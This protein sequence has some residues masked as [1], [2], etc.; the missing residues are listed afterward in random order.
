VSAVLA[1]LVIS[2]FHAVGL[3]YYRD[4]RV[5]QGLGMESPLP[6]ELAY[7]TLFLVFGLV[8]VALLTFALAHTTLPAAARAAVRRGARRPGLAAAVTAMA[9]GLGCLLLAREV[10]DDGV[11]S[12]DEHVYQFIAQT[13][14]T[15]ALTA[16]SP[17]T[18]LEF[19]FEQFVVV[20]DKV[21]Y[22]KYPIGF[23]LLLAAGQALGIERAVV[24]AL[25]GLC[26]LLLVW[27]GRKEFSPGAVMVALL[28]FGLSPQVWITGA[29]L[30]SQ[31]A[32]AACLLGAVGCLLEV[33]RGGPRAAVGTASAGALLAYGILVRPMPGILFAVVAIAWLAAA[34][35]LGVGHVLTTREWPLLL[36]PLAIGPAVLL[37]TNY[38][39]TGH[40]LHSGYQAIHGDAVVLH[41][42]LA[43]TALSVASSVLR[44]NFWLFGWPLS[45]IFCLLARRTPVTLLFWGLIAAEIGYR[46]IAP[47]AGIG[48]VGPVYFYEVVP[49]LCLLTAD[50]IVQLTAR[51]T[52]QSEA[53]TGRALRSDLVAAAIL[54]ATIVNLSLF[55]PY[56]LGDAA[57]SGHSG[58][59]VFRAL[60]RQDV[61]HA[62]VFHRGVVPPSTGLSWAYFPRPNSP[63]LDDD[64][65]FVTMQPAPV[66]RNVEFWKRR[67]PDREAWVFDWDPQ[68]GP[69]LVPLPAFLTF[70]ERA[71]PPPDR[72]AGS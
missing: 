13:L 41:S 43:P 35:R 72:P 31:P 24:P 69:R 30:L 15:G 64:V 34:P 39:Q 53:G 17:G 7:Y 21:R 54:S 8:A 66:A 32:A 56:K 25:T 68:T 2:S 61:H 50:G 12:D 14:R 71:S 5:P 22:G 38:V 1:A 29:S 52:R 65:L 48:T 45:L 10:L 9:L 18:D 11:L 3:Q 4:F 46:L 63:Q 26:A 57:R 42:T 67:F 58:Q 55:L 40:P 70:L 37:W 49:L 33:A 6:A 62:L 59:A 60:R 51:G 23:P 28:L 20:T 44:L 16:P 36:L 47:K 19:F 27:V